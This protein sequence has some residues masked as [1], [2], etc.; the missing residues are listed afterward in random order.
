MRFRNLI[1]G[2]WRC[3]VNKPLYM[4]R[5]LPWQGRRPI[6]WNKQNRQPGLLHQMPC[7]EK[8]AVSC[9][10]TVSWAKFCSVVRDNQN[11]KLCCSEM[12]RGT[13][14]PRGCSSERQESDIPL[15][16]NH[17]LWEL[18]KLVQ[19]TVVNLPLKAE[20][21]WGHCSTT[22]HSKPYS[23]VLC[24]SVCNRFQI[25]RPTSNHGYKQAGGTPAPSS[26]K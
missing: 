5:L 6:P 10:E 26:A 15:H 20:L 16:Q 7:K 21:A 12:P 13:S 23:A 18:Q 22:K 11:H 24:P 3:M 14:L 8:L 25:W 2:L 17:S 1:D 4:S 19:Q 9:Q